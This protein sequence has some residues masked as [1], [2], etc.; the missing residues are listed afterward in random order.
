M[1]T[2]PPAYLSYLLSFS[3]SICLPTCYISNFLRIYLTTYPHACLS[4]CHRS[5]C[6]SALYSCQVVGGATYSHGELSDLNVPVT[7]AMTVILELGSRRN[8]LRRPCYRNFYQSIS[9]LCCGMHKWLYWDYPL[10]EID[11]MGIN[12]LLHAMHYYCSVTNA[13]I[14][15][16]LLSP[17][18][19]VTAQV[20]SINGWRQHRWVLH[21]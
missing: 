1:L 21:S 4:V 9:C 20:N 14:R 10:H 18:V 5:V 15:F 8:L 3:L 17:T 19:F 2:G 6:L 16:L 7:W 13:V 11:Y 12:Y